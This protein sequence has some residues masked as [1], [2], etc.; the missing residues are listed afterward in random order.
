MPGVKGARCDACDR[1]EARH[2]KGTRCGEHARGSITSSEAVALEG[3]PIGKIGP[4]PTILAGYDPS[5]PITV[6]SDD[7]EPRPVRRRRPR[8]PKA[9]REQFDE[10]ITL[11]EEPEDDESAA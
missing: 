10:E 11:E 6:F 5:R 4:V 1:A 7:E 2:G 9:V 8:V 3:L